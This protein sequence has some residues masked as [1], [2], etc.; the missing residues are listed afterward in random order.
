MGTNLGIDGLVSGIDTTALIEKLMALE[1]KPLEQAQAKKSDLQARSNAWRDVNTRLYSLQTKVSALRSASTFQSRKVTLGQEDYFT[2]TAK[3]GAAVSDYQV[4]V[5][6]LA[7]AHTVASANIASSTTSLG[8]A[9]TIQINGKEVTIKSTDTL[10]S[11]ADKINSTPGIGVYASVVKMGEDQFKMTLTSAQTGA[12]NA[13]QVTDG[14]D[15]LN[16][17]GLLDDEGGF[18]EVIQNGQDAQIKV[19]GLTVNRSSNTIDDVITGVTLNLKKEGAS[20]LSVGVDKDAIVK[21]V[22]DFVDQY[23]STMS[24]IQDATKYDK[25]TKTKGALYGETTLVYLQSEIRGYLSKTNSSVDKSVNQLALIG[26][27]TGAY[28]SGVEN[29]KSGT[30]VLDE[31]KLRKALDEHFDDVMKLFGAKVDNVAAASNGATVTASSQLGPEYPAESLID[32]RTS[33]AEWGNGGGWSDNTPGQFPDTVEITFNT[34]R[35]IGSINIY[36]L[37]SEMFPASS[38]GVRDLTIEYWD[39]S[40]NAWKSLKQQYDTD[41]DLEI[42]GNTRSLIAVD[43]NPVNTTKIRVSVTA[44]NGDNDYSRLTEIQVMEKNDGVFSSLYDK[45]NSLTRSGGIISDKRDSIS[46]QQEDLDDRI[47]YLNE[48]LERKEEAYRT[49]FNAMETALSKLQN[50]ASSLSTQIAQLASWNTK[51]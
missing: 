32:G 21:A 41:K 3:T 23:N 10:S 14:G 9:G 7:K 24:F 44:T 8:Y 51:S 40:A 17:L 27:S 28:N 36:T 12:A 6:R 30:L 37:D 43:F 47:E 4:E 19:N 2:A 39:L 29:A 48:Q 49:K 38:Y 46:E 18:A 16:N 13:I 42:T 25:E 34:M 15:V 22:K 5:V 26:V 33:S 45:L 50:Q 20:N 11:I 35:T 31:A 1:R